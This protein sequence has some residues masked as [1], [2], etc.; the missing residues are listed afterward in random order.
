M[1]R[2]GKPGTCGSAVRKDTMLQCKVVWLDVQV[3]S[4]GAGGRSGAEQWRRQRVAWVGG[5]GVR[6]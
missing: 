4:S 1:F 6:E 3:G 5:K 2:D